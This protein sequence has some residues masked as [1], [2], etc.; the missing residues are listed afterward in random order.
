VEIANG[1]DDSDCEVEDAQ[2]ETDIKAAK[3]R[4]HIEQEFDLDE[5]DGNASG[6]V[7]DLQRLLVA[8]D[9]VVDDEDVHDDGVDDESVRDDDEVIRDDEDDDDEDDDDDEP[10]PDGK[11]E[12]SEHDAVRDDDEDDDE[13][14]DADE[15]ILRTD[16]VSSKQTND[17]V[18]NMLQDIKDNPPVEDSPEKRRRHRRGKNT[19]PTSFCTLAPRGPL[20]SFGRAAFRIPSF[21]VYPEDPLLNY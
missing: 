8:D 21:I 12:L 2:L 9:E 15:A 7:A 19:S 1:I 10:R 3:M 5:D 6:K 20:P 13:E 17:M 14:D 11:H 18:E 4:A 16:D